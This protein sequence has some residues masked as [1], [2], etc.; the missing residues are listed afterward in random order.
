MV[1]LTRQRSKRRLGPREAASQDEREP[2][3][4]VPQS[5]T[6][7]GA[8]TTREQPQPL[9]DEAPPQ[10]DDVKGQEEQEP[11]PSF[12]PPAKDVEFDIDADE[13]QADEA[14]IRVW[15]AYQRWRVT[16]IRL[17]SIPKEK[18]YSQSISSFFFGDDHPND[19]SS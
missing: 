18:T 5:H 16:K 15:S 13:E 3:D 7:D 2:P 17:S 12:S 10:D 8:A 1:F 11:P 4:V 14:S 19:R 6:R 9:E